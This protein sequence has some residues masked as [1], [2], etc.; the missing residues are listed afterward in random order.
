MFAGL[1]VLFGFALIA[2]YLK[3]KT[4]RY[5]EIADSDL[6]DDLDPDL[7]DQALAPKAQ[8]WDAAQ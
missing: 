6:D 4:D 8:D 1:L 3:V 5:Q 2:A 7:V